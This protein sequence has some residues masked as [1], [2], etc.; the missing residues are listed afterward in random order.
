MGRPKKKSV[1]ETLKAIEE[2]LGIDVDGGNGDCHQY[3]VDMGGN[4]E[5]LPAFDPD[6][7]ANVVAA[8][9][10]NTL[11][12]VYEGCYVKIYKIRPLTPGAKPPQFMGSIPDLREIP[13]LDIYLHNLVRTEGWGSGSYKLCIIKVIG[14]KKIPIEW[15]NIELHV[16]IDVPKTGSN[17]NGNGD[18][19]S[20]VQ[21]YSVLNK[22][23]LEAVPKGPDPGSLAAQ[24]MQMFQSGL[25]MAKSQLSPQQQQNPLDLVMQ[26]VKLGIV[27][28]PGQGAS[29]NQPPPDTLTMLRTFKELLPPAPATADPWKELKSMAELGIIDLQRK[30]DDDAFGSLDKAVNLFHALAPILGGGGEKTT[31]T[32]ELIRTIGPQTGEIVGK[33]TDTVNNVVNFGKEKLKARFGIAGGTS[34][35]PVIAPIATP[36]STPDNYKISPVSPASPP[37]PPV[38]KKNPA[39]SLILDAIKTSDISFYPRLKE[40]IIMFAGKQVLDSLITKDVS[41]DT[42]LQMLSSTLDEPEFYSDQ[43]KQYLQGFLDSMMVKA[44]CEKCG[45]SFDLTRDEFLEGVVCDE[46]NEPL[47]EIE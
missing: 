43:A 34:P 9:A 15:Q 24:Q 39:I 44:R 11:S 25:E 7:D 16:P 4:N 47:V 26:L 14:D 41:V 13:D 42:F 28:V 29:Q 17:G 27:Q 19:F 38:Q 31:A 40:L 45:E 33:I 6:S 18:F 1:T 2:H 10:I 36:V 30:K 8:K 35:Q 5:P 20:Q 3:T 23:L 37:S 12:P 32:T 21:Q 22:A 46:C